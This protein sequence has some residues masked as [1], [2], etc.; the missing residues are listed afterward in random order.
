VSNDKSQPVTSEDP[1]QPNPWRQLQQ[2]VA[3]DSD[4]RRYLELSFKSFHSTGD[5]P[6]I[7]ILQRQLLRER[8]S[9]DLYRIGDRIPGGLGTNPVR[10]DNRC[11]LTIA[12]IA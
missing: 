10:V 3:T 6:D 12:G 9:L 1:D 7:E 4:L 11:Q 2:L 8:V 5:W